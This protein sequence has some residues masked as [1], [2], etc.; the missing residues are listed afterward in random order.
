M[1]LLSMAELLKLTRLNHDIAQEDVASELGVHKNTVA[2]WENGRHGVPAFRLRE[3]ERLYG[4]P[5]DYFDDYSDPVSA[6]TEIKAD[7]AEIKERITTL[8]QDVHSL[9]NLNKPKRRRA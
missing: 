2:N 9:L 7:V 3:L 6:V 1:D 8:E 4:L 5:E